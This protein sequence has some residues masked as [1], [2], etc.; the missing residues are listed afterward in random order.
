MLVSSMGYLY[1]YLLMPNSA[2]DCFNVVPCVIVQLWY[3]VD[4]T[5][6]CGCGILMFYVY[7]ILSMYTVSQKKSRHF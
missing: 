4:T 3:T 5:V 2:C 1:L 7:S 6:D